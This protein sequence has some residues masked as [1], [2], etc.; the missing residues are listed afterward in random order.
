MTK[1]NELRRFKDLSKKEIRNLTYEEVD[2]FID[3]ECAFQGLPLIPEKPEEPTPPEMK[4]VEE[5]IYCIGYD[6]KF[7]NKEDAEEVLELL[8]SKELVKISA[9][10]QYNYQRYYLSLDEYSTPKITIEKALSNVNYEKYENTLEKYTQENKTYQTVIDKIKEIKKER[11]EIHNK[12]MNE[13]KAGIQEK[14]KLQQFELDLK[15][16]LVLA[17]N[18]KKIALKFLEDSCKYQEDKELL[19]EFIEE[20]E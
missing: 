19:K 5:N 8:K 10:Y 15:R 20:N 13:F 6:W 3:L 7:K 2:K 16:Y 4:D 18:N 17:D 1:E 14:Q 11:Q 12:I 9:N